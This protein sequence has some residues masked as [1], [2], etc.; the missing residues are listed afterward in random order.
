MHYIKSVDSTELQSLFLNTW[1]VWIMIISIWSMLI[2]AFS[3]TAEVSFKTW[4][5]N[6]LLSLKTW[7]FIFKINTSDTS[8]VKQTQLAENHESNIENEVTSQVPAERERRFFVSFFRKVMIGNR[9]L[10]W[11][12]ATTARTWTRTA[13]KSDWGVNFMNKF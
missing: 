8:A 9:P 12:S 7:Q 1:L 3:V 6:L 5:S 4:S 13:R 11:T 2:L 10:S